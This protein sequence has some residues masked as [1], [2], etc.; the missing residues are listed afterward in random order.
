MPSHIPYRSV[1]SFISC[2]TVW[3]YNRNRGTAPK[4][5]TIVPDAA[6]GTT[7]TPPTTRLLDMDGRLACADAWGGLRLY[8]WTPSVGNSSSMSWR[9]CNCLQFRGS[10]IACMERLGK[11][12]VAVSIEPGQESRILASATSLSL[13]RP[14]GVCVV[15]MKEAT[16]KAVLDAHTDTV[17]CMC[18]LPGGELLTAGGRL[19]ATVRVWDLSAGALKED[20]EEGDD[21]KVL[22][23]AKVM[24]EPGYVFDLKVLPDMKGSAAYA[25]ASARY[26]V[27]KIVI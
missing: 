4:E 12:L 3:H 16:I 7:T 21:V 14:R 19:D 6:E 11:D 1:H 9:Q 23:D 20:Q 2:V 22:T 13:P 25:V 15:D 26:N 17:R 18:P 27:I 5:D 24:K 8:V 10:S